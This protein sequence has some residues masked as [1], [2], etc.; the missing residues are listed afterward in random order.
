MD[1]DFENFR[2]GELS[3]KYYKLNR[4]IYNFVNFNIYS[5]FVWNYYIII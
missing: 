3:L 1:N 4:N 5:I 2:K